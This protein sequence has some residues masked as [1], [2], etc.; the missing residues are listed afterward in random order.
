MEWGDVHKSE[1][2]CLFGNILFRGGG[3]QAS[4]VF[5]QLECDDQ[6]G[7][8]QVV[9]LAWACSWST[10]HAARSWMGRQAGKT[11]YTAASERCGQRRG[12]SGTKRLTSHGANSFWRLAVTGSLAVWEECVTSV[13]SDADRPCS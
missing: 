13:R 7:S 4:I 10:N 12:K 5:E 6:R 11:E 9:L 3:G 2:Q 1:N 8:V